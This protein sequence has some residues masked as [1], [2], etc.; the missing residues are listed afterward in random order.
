[1]D[2][3]QLYQAHSCEFS[4]DLNYYL[5]FCRGHATLELFAGFGR[6]SN[7]LVKQGVSLETVEILPCYSD[8]ISLPDASKHVGDV[9]TFSSD[10]RFGRIF[11]AY[12]S[13]CLLTSDVDLRNFFTMIDRQLQPG[14]KAS[15][16]YFHPDYWDQAIDYEFTLNGKSVRAT[17][18]F[19][20][21][22]REQKQGVWTDLYYLN[23]TGDKPALEKNVVECSYPVRIVEDATD[24]LPFLHGLELEFVETVESFGR[25]RVVEPGWVDFVFVKG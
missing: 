17:P 23:D 9:L 16:S 5:D 19:D 14:G 3:Y 6:V 15:L 7:F 11:A 21:S 2:P 24:L 13:F 18:A 12:N 4:D 22:R 20:L 25:E 1:M 10:K 8:Q